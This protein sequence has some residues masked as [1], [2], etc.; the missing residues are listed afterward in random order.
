MI[1]RMFGIFETFIIQPIFNLL[2]FIYAM[3]P[4]NDFGVAIIIFTLITR[5]AMWPL[6]KKQLHQTK[7]MREMQ[8]DI[9]KIKKETK[10]DR[11][12]ESQMMMELYKEKGVN[13]M[14]SIGL[15]LVQLPIFIGLFSALRSLES[16]ARLIHLPYSFIRSMQPV[17]EILADVTLKT[18][19][20]VNTLQTGGA[21][22]EVADKI[23][24]TGLS[25]TQPITTIQLE[26]LTSDQLN[27]IY[28]DVLVNNVAG[29]VEKLVHGPFFDQH[30]FGVIDL[31]R[32][33]IQ[34]GMPLYWPL[35]LIAVLAGVM[36]YLQ[37]KQIT[38]SRTDEE[39]SQK[40]SIRQI[41]K[42][43]SDG[44]DPDQSEIN[45]AVSSRMSLFFAP[46]IAYISAISLGGLAV[47][48]LASGTIGYL[49][50]RMVLRQD[51]EEMEEIADEPD[52]KPEPKKQPKKSTTTKK[53]KSKKASSNK[54]PAKRN[55]KKR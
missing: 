46:M 45:A 41:L 22:S 37:T 54:K 7:M 38:A 31:S 33:A 1:L 15:L 4:G 48:F 35:L 34:A 30:L 12:L 28:N 50:Q 11:A 19:E 18:N 21:N 23:A 8:P 49:Q 53:T 25:V 42:E 9:K 16:P 27:F 55:K 52:P 20:A 39:K 5:F 51:V 2:L 6:L 26:A 24:T 13:P 36:Q 43:S 3:I 32:S 47:Y 14:S 40:K 29:T 10:G 44:K 17:Q